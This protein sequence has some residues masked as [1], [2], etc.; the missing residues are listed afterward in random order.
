MAYNQPQHGGAADSYYSQQGQQDISMQQQPYSSEQQY[1]NQGQG[2]YQQQYTPQTQQ[3]P[4][5]PPR[6]EAQPHQDNVDEKTGF[7]QQFKLDKPKF[8]DL[9]A[10]LLFLATFAG[11]VA[12]SGLVL[13]G[14][15]HTKGQQ[16]D[17]IYNG[18]SST[19]FALNTNT[20]ILL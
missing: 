15:S 6:F 2:P 7:N 11:F 3:Y 12:V 20:I 13:Y 8:N 4:Q 1:Q 10:A 16:G 5:E 19:T 17:G 18:G 9:W 14:Y